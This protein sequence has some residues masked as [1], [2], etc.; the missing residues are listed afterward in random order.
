MVKIGLVVFELKWGENENC[1]TIGRFSFIWHTGVL[2]QIGI[3]QFD[4]SKLIGN[5][6][7]VFLLR[8]TDLTDLARCVFRSFIRPSVSFL[9]F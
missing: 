3:S 7:G 5:H 4:F 1:A 2:K 6:G 8:Q 9:V